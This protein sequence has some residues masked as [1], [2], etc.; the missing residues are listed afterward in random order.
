MEEALS[1]CDN[2]LSFINKELQDDQ[3]IL[4]ADFLAFSGVHDFPERYDCATLSWREMKKFLESKL[5]Q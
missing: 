4:A 2:F 1:L 3:L 5:D